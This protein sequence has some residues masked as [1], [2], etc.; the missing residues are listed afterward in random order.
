MYA[1]DTTCESV[2]DVI[3]TFGLGFFHDHA[4]TNALSMETAGIIFYHTGDWACVGI[5][6][7]LDHV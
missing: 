3:Q 2:S 4:S 5:P 1:N 6:H 7:T